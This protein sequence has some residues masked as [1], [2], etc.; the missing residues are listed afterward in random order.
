ME[1]SIIA[2][3]HELLMKPPKLTTIPI[4]R[5]AIALNSPLTKGSNR[6]EYHFVK[7][8]EKEKKTNL[9]FTYPSLAA[10]DENGNYD[11]PIFQD[12]RYNHI[13]PFW[14][15]FREKLQEKLSIKITRVLY[16]EYRKES[17]EEE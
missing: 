10:E 6:P 17:E 5:A 12:A 8:L 14:Q 13:P 7:F 11:S 9:Y 2:E 1:Q 3:A 4:Q 16:G 15:L